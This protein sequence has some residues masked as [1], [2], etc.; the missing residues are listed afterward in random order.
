MPFRLMVRRLILLATLIDSAPVCVDGALLLDP[1]FCI[2]SGRLNL[3][4]LVLDLGSG[5]GRR[6]IWGDD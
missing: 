1:S 5:G 4:L 2:D 3:M 6:A